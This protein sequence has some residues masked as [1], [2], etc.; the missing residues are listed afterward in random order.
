MTTF[1]C[2]SEGVKRPK[3]PG[4]KDA[5]IAFGNRLVQWQVFMRFAEG[6]IFCFAVSK[7]PENPAANK[8]VAEGKF[9]NLDSLDSCFRRNDTGCLQ[10][11]CFRLNDNVSLSFWGSETTEESSGNIFCFAFSKRSVY[12][13]ISCDLP[14]ARFFALLSANV[15]RILQLTSLLPK[16]RF[17]ALLSA[18]VLFI[19]RFH[20][21][22][23]RHLKSSES[24]R[25]QGKKS[26]L[27]G[28]LLS[29][30]WHGMF[31]GFL[32]SQEW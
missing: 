24:C 32:L 5:F 21:I 7:R 30:K 19:C 11:S 4:V 3:N 13:P 14:K 31:A 25:R 1:L 9:K 8:A 23:R 22:C 15:L 16:A 10:D 18:N 20:A 28:F 27:A 12:L 6:K 17:F 29:L 2:H 26:G